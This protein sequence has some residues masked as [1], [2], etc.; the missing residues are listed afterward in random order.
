MTNLANTVQLIGF[1]LGGVF[2]LITILV[3][4][5][6]IRLAIFARREEIEMEKLIG[7][8]RSYV[9][10]PFLIEAELYGIIS[11]VLALGIGYVLVLNFLPAIWTGESA[12]GISTALLNR[13][14]IGWMPL[15]AIGM[16]VLGMI[17]GNLSA[18]L[19]VKK[20]LHY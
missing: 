19:A 17:I 6:T 11:G 18:R 8:E 4:F 13:V 7:A 9:R 20:Y 12:G 14:L 2:L 10:G 15:V 5:N 16:V 1:V 3:I